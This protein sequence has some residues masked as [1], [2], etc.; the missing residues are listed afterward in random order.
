MEEGT[1]TEVETKVPAGEDQLFEADI[2]KME[3]YP[4]EYGAPLPEVPALTPHATPQ[5]TGSGPSMRSNV[6]LGSCS[7]QAVASCPVMT[8]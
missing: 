2:E 7:T 3:F 1:A 4:G 5:C 6:E 8:I